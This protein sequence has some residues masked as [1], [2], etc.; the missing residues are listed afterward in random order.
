MN[1][2][3]HGPAAEMAFQSVLWERSA[4][5]PQAQPD[6]FEDLNLDQV[7]RSLISGREQYELA[8]FFYS[9]LRDPNEVRYR[10]EVFHDLEKPD[11]LDS[12]S[13]FASAMQQTR[14]HRRA[15]E[16]LRYE[17]QKQAWFVDAA[18]TYCRAVASLAAEL[19]E[20]DLTSR[21]AR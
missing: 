5:Q 18:E 13:R 17:L 3:Q 16:H 14:E 21:R 11:V 1:A 8:P 15:A 2:D 7:L 10:H 4:D 19:A 12:I 20:R 9:P 6:F